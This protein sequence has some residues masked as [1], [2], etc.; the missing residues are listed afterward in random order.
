[1]STPMYRWTIML[2]ERGHIKN[3]HKEIVDKDFIKRFFD[4]PR[5]YYDMH[6]VAGWDSAYDDPDYVV[7][8]FCNDTD[9]DVILR[10]AWAIWMDADRYSMEAAAMREYLADMEHN[11]NAALFLKRE[12]K[13]RWDWL[14]DQANLEDDFKNWEEQVDEALRRN[15]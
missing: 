7:D 4:L 10:S 14:S 13:R 8:F 9:A 3:F 15:G 6:G 11:I 2:T 5:I 12:A 1:M